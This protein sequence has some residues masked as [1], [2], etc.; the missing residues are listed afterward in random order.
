MK[1]FLVLMSFFA[2]TAMSSCEQDDNDDATP[3]CSNGSF[4]ATVNGTAF[5]GST[6]N[7]TLVRLTDNGTKAK[8][9][10]IRAT[11]ADGKKILLTVTNLEGAATGKCLK[12]DTYYLDPLQNYTDG[13]NYEGILGTYMTS[14]STTAGQTL[15]YPGKPG[16]IT[17]TSCNES[18]Q[19]V[20][21]TF[22]FTADQYGNPP[23][24]V[25]SGS[26]TN[27][28]YTFSE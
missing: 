19:Q 12:A 4:T 27:M 11:A 26:F 10:D 28:C 6:Y 21:G 16:S 23:S 25:I 3:G 22:S 7:N 14:A 15:P 24:Y 20:S 18:T 2:I 8:R 13:T 5:T 1:T 17:I 9:L